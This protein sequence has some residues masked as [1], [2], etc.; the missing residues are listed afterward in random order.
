MEVVPLDGQFRAGGS[1]TYGEWV[2]RL[3][4]LRDGGPQRW[5]GDENFEVTSAESP[6]EL[7]AV[8]HSRLQAGF[9][10]RM[11]AGFCWPWSNPRKDD[12]L[13]L[14]VEVGDWVRPWNVKGERGVG[15][16]PPSALWA[17]ADGGFEQIGCV[18]TAQG[19]EYDWNGVIIGP[20]LL[21][22]NG[23]LITVRSASKDPALKKN[24]ITD[25]QADRLIRNTYKVLLT[26][27]M[28]GTVL[29]SV[30]EETQE[31]LAEL[32]R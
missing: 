27:G 24:G 22:R 14:D 19:F 4:G 15:N 30:D 13:V 21:W 7:E 23:R 26:R 2:L 1:R 3:L 17:T 25:E 16:F 32:V 9:S 11:T 28:V 18:Y 29:Y 10:A 12:T 5:T 20:D 31:F 6:Y 8:L